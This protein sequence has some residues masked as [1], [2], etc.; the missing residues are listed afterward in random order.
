MTTKSAI[1]SKIA[2]LEREKME[3]PNCQ[4]SLIEIEI[5]IRAARKRLAALR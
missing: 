2:R 1:L 3:Y 4:G 5:D